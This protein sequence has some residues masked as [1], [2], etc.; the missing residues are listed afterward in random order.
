MKL[1]EQVIK[2]S[3]LSPTILIAGGAGFI[4]THLAE[5]L[6][7]QD[8]RVI[9]I[10]QLDTEKDVFLSKLN[11]NPKFAAFNAN[12]NEG[13][14]DK[15][16]SVDYI[17][18]LASVESYLFSKDRVDL[19]SLLTNAIGTKNLLDLAKKSEAKFLLVSSIDV[20]EGLISPMSLDQY[21][22][23]TPE[24]EK[25]YSLSEAKRYAEAL[26]WEYYKNYQTDVRITRLPEIYGPKMPLDSTGSLGV[27]LKNV[28]E[29]K[30]IVIQGEGTEAEYY[31][32]ISDA[33]NGII[34]ALFNNNTEGQIFTLAPQE[35]HTTLEI[36]YLLKSLADSEISVEFKSKVNADRTRDP[37]IPDRGNLKL[38]KWEPRV[39]LK[40]GVKSTMEWFGYNPNEHSFKPTKLIEQK[41]KT[42]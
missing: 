23:T 33:I 21:F 3:A 5:K 30:N 9:V 42:T 38:L 13:I 8:A 24:E 16:Q 26:V 39:D 1:N 41:Q 14:P 40:T 4:G 22:G 34:K 32:F 19:N 36:A 20:Y 29:H 35:P 10:D 6:L 27:F 11:Q 7:T 2:K 37:R 18:H 12:I 28:M 31:T 15:I 25:R 17:V